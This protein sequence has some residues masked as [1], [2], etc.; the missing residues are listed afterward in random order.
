MIATLTIA[1]SLSTLFHIGPPG[2]SLSS[3][4]RA[5]C[6]NV[7]SITVFIATLE[8]HP[9]LSITSEHLEVTRTKLPGRQRENDQ[10]LGDDA[11]QLLKRKLWVTFLYDSMSKTYPCRRPKHPERAYFP[12]VVLALGAHPSIVELVVVKL[13]LL[14]G[15]NCLSCCVQYEILRRLQ[16]VACVPDFEAAQHGIVRYH[17]IRTGH[18]EARV[19]PLDPQLVFEPYEICMDNGQVSSVAAL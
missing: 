8:K 10:T 5:N 11:R 18:L 12:R 6:R 17:N 9:N 4:P 7:S 13:S 19:W 3:S 15:P 14:D 2:V 1:Q 16:V